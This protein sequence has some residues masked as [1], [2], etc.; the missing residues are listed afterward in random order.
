MQWVVPAENRMAFSETVNDVPEG[1]GGRR[2]N[3]SGKKTG[4]Q[5]ALWALG[6]Q[7]SKC[8]GISLF[9][10]QQEQIRGAASWPTVGG[11]GG[12]RAADPFA[13]SSAGR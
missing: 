9:R 13:L 10:S 12:W 3:R 8:H 2:G 5:K 4:K 7:M 1:G 6:C 11:G